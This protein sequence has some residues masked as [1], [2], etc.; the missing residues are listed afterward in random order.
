MTRRRDV[1]SQ[2]EIL[3]LQGQHIILKMAFSP[4]GYLLTSVNYG[5]VLHVW[6]APSWAEIEQAERSGD[7]ERK[8][9]E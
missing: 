8:Q 4:D 9:D 7:G 2:P 3:T 6:R 1:R 5:G